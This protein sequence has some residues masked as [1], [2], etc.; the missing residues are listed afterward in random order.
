MGWETTCAAFFMYQGLSGYW[1]AGWRT[2]LYLAGYEKVFFTIAENR[3]AVRLAMRCEQSLAYS[4]CGRH[5]QAEQRS[6]SFHS[7]PGTLRLT[8]V[9]TGTFFVRTWAQVGFQTS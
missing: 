6:S 2:P 7:T 5:L 3:L 1:Q 4:T 9:L 8:S